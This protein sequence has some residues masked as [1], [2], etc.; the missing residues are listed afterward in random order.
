M[1]SPLLILHMS[2][3]YCRAA[4]RAGAILIPVCELEL[5]GG[6]RRIEAVTIHR[7]RDFPGGGNVAMRIQGDGRRGGWSSLPEII[8]CGVLWQQRQGSGN[9]LSRQRSHTIP[10]ALV[11]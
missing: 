2:S 4:L 9:S 1:A 7:S 6:K 11:H 10:R 5:R 8:C 3:K